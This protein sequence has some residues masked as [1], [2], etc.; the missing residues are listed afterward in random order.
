MSE[1]EKE[2]LTG[3]N[4]DGI[5]E[6]DNPLPNWWLVTFL[7]SII[8]SFLYYIHY[9]FDVGPSSDEELSLALQEIES[10]R[11]Q[12]KDQP[13]DTESLSVI[14]NDPARVSEGKTVFDAK[15]AVCHG[16]QLEGL[17]GPNLVDS[18]WLNKKGSLAD[19]YALVHEG[20]PEKGMPA[21]NGLIPKS[22]IESV[23]VYIFSKKG[24]PT[25]GGKGPEGELIPE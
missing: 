10:L 14:L 23:A 2:N 8:F 24:T 22:E 19:I 9:E 13:A 20:V 11:A 16:Q 3:H 7:V 1:N 6:L 4:Y 5:E 25:S 21:W 15:C 12:H 17:I 18:Y